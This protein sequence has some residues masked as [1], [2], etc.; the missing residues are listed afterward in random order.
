MDKSY[1][2]LMI[3]RLRFQSFL[4]VTNALF[5]LSPAGCLS[6]SILE[7]DLSKRDGFIIE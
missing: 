6:V 7:V 3:C 2:Y 5:T 1:C 4:A